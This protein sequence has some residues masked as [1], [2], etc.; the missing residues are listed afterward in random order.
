M[1]SPAIN[2]T[3]PKRDLYPQIRDFLAQSDDIYP[4]IDR[5]WDRCVVPGIRS[6]QRV[7]HVAIDN[8]EVVA[9]GIGK[10]DRGSAKLC[11]LRVRDSHQGQGLGERLLHQ[12]VSDLLNRECKSVFYTISEKVFAECSG[13]FE[14]YKFELRHWQKN[15]YVR[16]WDELEFAAPSNKL[17]IAISTSR[18]PVVN[19]EVILLSIKPK[20]ASLIRSGEKLV[21]FRRSFSNRVK[22]ALVLLYETH[23]IQRIRSACVVK[24]VEQS[25]PSDLWNRFG[26]FAGVSKSAFDSYFAGATRGAALFLDGICSL[27]N[28]IAL[29]D[30]TFRGSGLDAPQSHRFV[31]ADSPLVRA[32][33]G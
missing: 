19:R 9:I 30:P 33:I 6:G 24:F 3:S 26:E 28:P 32:A 1:D 12:T 21:E 15:L 16:G 18:L 29:N 2:V 8:N 7:C 25:T 5:W 20:Y 10:H 27:R 23:P 13:F 22:D 11:T 31:N 4:G 14:P 17:R